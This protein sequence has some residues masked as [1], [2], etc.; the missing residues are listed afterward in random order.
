MVTEKVSEEQVLGMELVFGNGKV[1]CDLQ[2]ICAYSSVF[3]VSWFLF[4][5]VV[6]VCF[7]GFSLSVEILRDLISI[8]G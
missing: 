5:L 7:R 3:S 8:V 4:C 1:G 6:V 2:D